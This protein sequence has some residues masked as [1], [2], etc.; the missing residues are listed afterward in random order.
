VT[1]WRQGSWE[2]R[3]SP[4]EGWR[5]RD[6]ERVGEREVGVKEVGVKGVEEREVR[7]KGEGKEVAVKGGLEVRAKVAVGMGMVA[8]VG[9]QWSIRKALP[10]RVP[11]TESQRC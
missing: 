10:A 2:G 1:S 9:R 11:W 8:W 7:V 5:A 4:E 6:G 3:E